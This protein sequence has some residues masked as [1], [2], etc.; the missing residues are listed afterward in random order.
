MVIKDDSS[1][2]RTCYHH[3][4]RIVKL[5]VEYILIFLDCSQQ[6]LTLIVGYLSV[7]IH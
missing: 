5:L 2:D 3:R 7:N 4:F 1:D 6:E